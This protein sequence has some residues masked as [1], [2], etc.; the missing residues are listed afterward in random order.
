LTSGQ[1]IGELE[2]FWFVFSSLGEMKVKDIF[3]ECQ[4]EGWVPL[5]VIRGEQTVVPCFKVH[6][7]AVNFAKRNLVKGELWGTTKLTVEDLQK[8]EKEW[9]EKKS[10]KIEK[11]NFPKL[12]GSK[13]KID[14]EI[15]DFVNKPDVFGTWG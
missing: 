8:I 2:N 12:V 5:V 11:M 6:S 1:K 4:K 7:D 14:V 13:A 9:I 15:Y 3:H 10:W